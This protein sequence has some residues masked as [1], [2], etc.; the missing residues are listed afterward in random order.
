[1]RVV[2]SPWP[3]VR[4]P[5][6]VGE[7]TRF[8]LESPGLTTG[9]F[10]HSQYIGGVPNQAASAALVSRSFAP[11]DQPG[12]DDKPRPVAPQSAGRG[13]LPVVSAQKKG[14]GLRKHGV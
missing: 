10:F 3:V 11:A 7:L 14:P 5:R 1:M 6:R 13:I 8:S 2:P 12:A 9:A 4:E